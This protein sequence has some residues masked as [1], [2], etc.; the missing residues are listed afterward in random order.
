MGQAPALPGGW[1]E[2][3]E[4]FYVGVGHGFL[5]GDQLVYGN[6]G[7]VSGP[8]TVKDGADYRR[9]AVK[10]PGN[11]GPVACFVD[12]LTRSRPTETIGGSWKIGEEL[13]YNGAVR[14]LDD[15]DRLLPGGRCEVVGPA[16]DGSPEGSAAVM[17]PG[18][19]APVITASLSRED[20]QLRCTLLGSCL[21]MCLATPDKL[22][23][24]EKAEV[25]ALSGSGSITPS[26]ANSSSRRCCRG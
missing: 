5:S 21:D 4:V 26:S 7:T 1:Q 22:V 11:S 24:P 16:P 2:D 6:R 20:E 15:G 3:E 9:V 17:F 13:V 18:H 19:S 14:S 10:F 8:S 25:F 23:I 12:A